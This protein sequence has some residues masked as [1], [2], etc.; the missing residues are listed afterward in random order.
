V[1]ITGGTDTSVS[2]SIHSR[3]LAATVPNAKLIVLPGVGHMVQYAAPDVV[4][5]EIEAM[6]AETGAAK[7]AMR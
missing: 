1:V 6:I 7:A 2:P 3:R 4:V 5:R